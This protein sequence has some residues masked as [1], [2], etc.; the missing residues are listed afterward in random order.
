MYIYPTV[1][2][3]GVSSTTIRGLLITALAPISKPAQRALVD[4]IDGRAG[5]VITPLGFAA[6]DKPVTIALTK[7][8]DIDEVI[9]FFNSSGV[10]TFS[11]EPD[12]FYNFAIYEQIDFERLIRF[13]TATVI[14]HVQPYK[15]PV[16]NILVE[17][18]PENDTNS[19]S[20]SVF[21]SGNIY[22]RP[23]LKVIGSGTIN[24]SVNGVQ[25]LILEL[26]ETS[27]TIYIDCDTMNAYAPDNTLLNRLVTGNYDNIKLP[28]GNNTITVTAAGNTITALSIDKY[29]RWI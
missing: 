7:G 5:D 12:K 27:Q 10:V 13:K 17:N 22:A 20:V 18:A 24:L 21:N 28:V 19:L 11:N 9:K 23:L 15:Y 1:T 16:K 25:M 14:F 29:I 26:G 6:Y 4:V 2:I 3:N 8:Y